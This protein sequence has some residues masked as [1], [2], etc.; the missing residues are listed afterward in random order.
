MVVL[1][2]GLA[3][4]V[5]PKLLAGLTSSGVV[6]ALVAVLPIRASEGGELRSLLQMAQTLVVIL[7]STLFAMELLGGYRNFMG[8]S[9]TRLVLTSLLAPAIGLGAF[10]LVVFGLRIDRLSRTLFFAFGF[11][12]A[13]L[14]LSYRLAIR[15]YKSH[16]RQ[17]GYYS[18][19]ALL[20]GGCPDVAQVT[21]YFE[22]NVA[23][24][25]HRI[26]G[27][28]RV[29]S[30]SSPKSD[31][32]VPVIGEVAEIGRLL[33]HQPIN[34]VIVIQSHDPG[35]LPKVIEECDYFGVTLR[36]VPAPLLGNRL[37][38]LRS[39]STGD[40]LRLPATLLRPIHY[41]SDAMFA[42]RLIDLAVSGTLLILLMPLLLLIA[43]G[44]KLATPGLPVLYP[45]RVVGKKG[46]PFVGYKFTTMQASSDAEKE[47]ERLQH[48][49]EMTGPVFKIR[50]DP[51]VTRFGG[52]LRRYSLNEL[53][54]LWSVLKGDMSL[55]GPRPAF[56]HE[57]A[58]YEDWQK[59]K[60]SVRP[61]LT[62]LWQVS[63][64]NKI[65]SFDEWVRLDLEYIDNWSLW[66]DVK[67]LARTVWA[68]A[69]G[70]GS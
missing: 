21:R 44:I 36:I 55:V 12:Q 60:L 58:R 9:R 46:R 5:T 35:W 23:Q 47:K 54:Q 52:L 19:N 66:L 29:P 16:R 30:D 61:G 69:S 45:W 41:D 25:A 6:S 39:A 40:G 53:P 48:L 11:F 63:G 18:R 4:L 64:R 34:D 42:K 7:P 17:A 1:S 68:V 70:S 56:P 22:E 14:L 49:N 28:L 27:C 59:R 51:R 33:I 3:Y 15:A 8:Q 43:L 10:A 57:L 20:I 31:Y 24:E 67:I 26:V 13:C 62:C 65:N 50:Q 37:R 38:D 2:M 32:A